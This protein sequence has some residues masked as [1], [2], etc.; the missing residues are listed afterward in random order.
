[1]TEIGDSVFIGL[2]TLSSISIPKSIATSGAGAFAG[3]R[4]LTSITIPDG[5]TDI[6]DSAFSGCSSLTN[7]TIPDSVSIIGLWAFSYSTSL[8]TITTSKKT[9][10]RLK[11]YFPDGVQLKDVYWWGVCFNQMEE[12]YWEIYQKWIS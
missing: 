11:K 3:C 2:S 12:C 4:S 9:F 10:D 6:G 5:V 7:I 8:K 1:M